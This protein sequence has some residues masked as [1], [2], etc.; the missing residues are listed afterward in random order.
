MLK[1]KEFVAGDYSTYFIPTFYPDGFSGEPLNSR[2]H[3]LVSL[4]TH[5]IKNIHLN[6]GSAGKKLS[7]DTLYISIGALKDAPSVDLRVTRLSESDYEVT[8]M[9]TNS[10]EVFSLNG[11]DFAY[12]SLV[13]LNLNG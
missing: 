12:N 8:N 3:H 2:D 10:T 11:F 9:E 5:N 6:Q 1:N 4:I 7:E 13:T